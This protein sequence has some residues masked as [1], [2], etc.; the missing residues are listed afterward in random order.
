MGTQV[1]QVFD[2]HQDYGTTLYSHCSCSVN[3]ILFTRSTLYSHWAQSVRGSCIRQIEIES[4]NVPGPIP[5]DNKMLLEYVLPAFRGPA[6]VCSV[7]TLL[8]WDEFGLHWSDSRWLEKF[9]ELLLRPKMSS[10]ASHFKKNGNVFSRF[11]VLSCNSRSA[12]SLSNRAS[13]PYSIGTKY[14][15]RWRVLSPLA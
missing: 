11:E 7:C 12:L 10:P 15:F 2:Y 3:R 4:G 1:Y 5:L 6:F 9:T 8:D 13:G 14:P